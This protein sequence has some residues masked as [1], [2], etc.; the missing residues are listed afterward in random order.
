MKTIKNIDD[1]VRIFNETPGALLIDVRARSEYKEG[2]I[3]GSIN[4]PLQMLDKVDDEAESF[5][6]PLFVYCY[7]GGR[8]SQ[9][10]VLLGELGYTDVRNIGG[11]ADYTGEVER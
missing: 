11:I 8:S 5:N 2:H 6:I 10:A 3:P 4:I 9:A 7:S 1:G